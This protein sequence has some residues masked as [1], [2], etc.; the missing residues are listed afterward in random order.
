MIFDANLYKPSHVKHS[1]CGCKALLPL[2]ACPLPLTCAR[3]PAHVFTTDSSHADLVFFSEALREGRNR[4]E[5]SPDNHLNPMLMFETTLEST[6]SQKPTRSHGVWPRLHRGSGPLVSNS[7]VTQ[8][9]LSLKSWLDK[10]CRQMPLKHSKAAS[11]SDHLPL[12]QL[13]PKRLWLGRCICH[14]PFEPFQATAPGGAQAF[15]S[16][17]VGLTESDRSHRRRSVS[18]KAVGLTEVFGLGGFAVVVATVLPET[19][20]V[21]PPSKGTQISISNCAFFFSKGM[22]CHQKVKKQICFLFNFLKS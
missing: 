8:Q 4:S 17:A 14:V 7:P 21:T 13:R 2:P 19:G 22:L 5:P 10:Y 15:T 11:R 18:P 1:A 3:L 12:A 6:L 9:P 20:G 16:K